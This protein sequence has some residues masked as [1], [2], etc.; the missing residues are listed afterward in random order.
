VAADALEIA[1]AARQ[2]V[3]I[4]KPFADANV[5]HVLC[6]A[7][8]TPTAGAAVMRAAELCRRYNALLRILSVMPEPLWKSA[9]PKEDDP[10]EQMRAEH[11]AQKAFLD[12]F[13]LQGVPLSRAIV[14]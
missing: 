13:D 6:A 7:D 1:R 3:W 14:W 10:E 2:D 5:G 11:E 8:T 9:A 12:Q 4:C